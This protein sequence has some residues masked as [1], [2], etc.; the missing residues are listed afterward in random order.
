MDKPIPLPG[1]G[2]RG[3]YL[4]A[5][6]R[7]AAHDLNNLLSPVLG[8]PDLLVDSFDPESQEYQDLM[9]IK[10]LAQ[11]SV[12]L[13]KDLQYLLRAER[14]DPCPVTTESLVWSAAGAAS[15]QTMLRLRPGLELDV[16]AEAGSE[17]TV[18]A[19]SAKVLRALDGLLRFGLSTAPDGARLTL[20]AGRSVVA[21]PFLET[22]GTAVPD[23]QG[24][25]LHIP[26]VPA[27]EETA[28][29]FFE[30]FWA[31][32]RFRGEGTGLETSLVVEVAQ[33]HDGFAGVTHRGDDGLGACLVLPV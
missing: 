27:D 1:S 22:V 24:I 14:H 12:F 10:M 13:V 26:H 25:E 28:R 31:H 16:R 18:P 30:P 6:L 21:G 9:E 8:Y 11:R 7:A 4:T 32:R 20:T 33:Q 5:L 19:V 29:R 23:G 3:E 15:I 17:V 2:D